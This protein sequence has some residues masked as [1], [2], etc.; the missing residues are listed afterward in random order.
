[1]HFPKTAQGRFCGKAVSSEDT[2]AAVTA[3]GS[4]AGSALAGARFHIRRPQHNDA[5]NHLHIKPVAAVQLKML[6]Q[7]L[8]G[9]AIQ[10]S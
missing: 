5:I 8:A 9:K 6:T 2:G 3:G 7:S 4:I 1:M 10:P